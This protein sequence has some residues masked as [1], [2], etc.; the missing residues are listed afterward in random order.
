[1]VGGANLAGYL[2]ARAE[3]APLTARA[4][5]EVVGNPSPDA[6]SVR[7][8][9]AQDGERVDTVG[10]AVDPPAT[11]TVVEVAYDPA[12]P[13]HVVVPGAQVLADLEA[14][15]GAAAFT[16]VLAVA[17]VLSAAWQLLTRAPALGR[18]AD[19]TVPARRVRVRRGLTTRSWLELDTGHWIPVH[20]D[21]QLTA[22]PSPS[23]VRPH[24]DPSGSAYVAVTVPGRDGPVRL[25]PS[26]RVRRTEPP[27]MR[28]DNPSAPDAQTL[29]ALGTHGWRRQ[30]H[31]DLPLLLLAPA[32]AA[33]WALAI[34]T[35]LI[36]WLATTLIAAPLA[37]HVAAL[38]GSDPS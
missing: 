26:G 20:F 12:A 10:L 25:A 36:G 16:A 15:S 31:S 14:A 6:V 24:G 27:G 29:A 18:P 19:R 3:L 32:L 7:W 28:T 37:L 11:G 38:R 1:V 2:G 34:G 8:T 5:G 9:P 22:L 17:L 13:Q 33:V 21:P 23:P 30:L 4:M 35:G